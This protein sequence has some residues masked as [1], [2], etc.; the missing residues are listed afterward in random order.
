MRGKGRR[1]NGVASP[2]GRGEEADQVKRQP[3][4][5][6]VATGAEGNDKSFEAAKGGEVVDE[7]DELS[8]DN[9]LALGN[10]DLC[11]FNLA[12][13]FLFLQVGLKV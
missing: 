3:L 8:E 4:I 9:V 7:V 13:L 2:E 11:D 5:L 6:G 1:E 10:G 12:V